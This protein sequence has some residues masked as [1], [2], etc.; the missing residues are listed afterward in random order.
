MGLV[1]GPMGSASGIPCKGMMSSV[2][3][4]R[5]LLARVDMAPMGLDRSACVET[6]IPRQIVILVRP[7]PH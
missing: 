4:V 5:P 3:R 2:G 7:F 1:G 6:S